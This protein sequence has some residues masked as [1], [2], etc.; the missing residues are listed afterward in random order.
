MKLRDFLET[1]GLGGLRIDLRFLE[2]EFSPSDADRKAAW[3][4][5]VELLTR[6][7]TQY[8]PP[9]AG[10][11][12]T[13]LKSVY[14]LFSLTREVLK[15]HGSGAGQFAK[16]ALPVLN[17][18]VRPF[19]A[20][21]HGLS[22]AGAFESAPR[23]IE[24]RRELGALQEHLRKYTRALASMAGVEDLTTLEADST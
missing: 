15:K 16:L 14:E 6:I 18:I 4:L 23:R 21:W 7:A 22:V 24:F 9:D 19:T 17:Q 11:E 10:D 2:G 13:A 3:D 5:Y 1:W 20:K 8:L 12:Q